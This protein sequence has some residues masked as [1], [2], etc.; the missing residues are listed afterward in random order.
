MS[1]IPSRCFGASVGSSGAV[2]S[3][4]PRIS[5]LSRPSVPPIAIPSTAAS[6]IACADS[7]RRSSW[8]PPW[9]IP[10][11]AWRS[12]PLRSCHSRQRPS[13]RCVRSIERAVYSRSAW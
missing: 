10:N 9:T 2:S 3:S 4:T 6:E 12:G 5:S 8:M 7:R 1:P 13:Q 11:T